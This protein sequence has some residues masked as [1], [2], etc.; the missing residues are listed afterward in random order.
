[1]ID[2]ENAFAIAEAID[3]RRRPVDPIDALALARAL[4]ALQPVVDAVRDVCYAGKGPSVF[5]D[6]ALAELVRT[7]DT[8]NKK[9]TL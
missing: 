9:A 5:V 6:N 3:T 7:F 8:L 1:M 4:R 2:L